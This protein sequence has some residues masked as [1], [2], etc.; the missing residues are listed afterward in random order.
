MMPED[1]VDTLRGFD[2]IYF[3]AV[4]DPKIPDHITLW[5]L[6]LA[7]C[8]GL[9]QYANVRPTRLLPGMTGP[10][11]AELGRKIDWV[12]VRENSEGEYAG[13]GGRAHVG[14]PL[15]TGLDVAVFTRTGVER[16]C[17][18][19]CELAMGRPRKRLT[20]VTKSNA[21]RHGMVFWDAVCR[22]VLAD[23]PALE[24]DFKLV[25][26]MAALMVTKPEAIDTVVAT[27]L[28]A[29]ILSDLASALTGSLG[30]GATANIN[31]AGDVPSM[32]EPIHGSAFDI[33]GK[34]IANPV[35]AFWTGAMMLEHLGERGA[36]ARLM[37]AIEKVTESGPRTPDLGGQAGSA[38]VTR[39]VLAALGA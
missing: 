28:H 27:N 34:G 8:Q 18:F 31:P 35:G 32:F 21:Q 17:R 14:L 16:I 9:D 24:V 30:N 3:G 11:K 10:L 26:A 1:G 38:D 2:A 33:V 37:T 7:I 25:D 19:A 23:F 15:E 20:V 13:V 12:I 22:D 6:R 4:G 39:A 36:A 5:E 29:D